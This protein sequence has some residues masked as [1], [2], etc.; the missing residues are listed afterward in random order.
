ME[1]EERRNDGFPLQAEGDF[2]LGGS[3]AV[4]GIFPDGLF[5]GCEAGWGVVEAGDGLL[6]AGAGKVAKHGLEG[7]KGGGGFAGL[8]GV[9]DDLVGR[10]PLDE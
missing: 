3:G 5:Q 10:G 9:G 8:A 7:A 6:E 1:A 4:A 2:G